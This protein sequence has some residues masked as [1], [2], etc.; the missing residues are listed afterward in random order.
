MKTDVIEKIKYIETHYPV[1]I[2]EYNGIKL[3]PFLRNNI[4]TLYYY[5]G[6]AP[7]ANEAQKKNKLWRLFTALK[8]E[9]GSSEFSE[10][11]FFPAPLF[12]ASAS[13]KI[14]IAVS[15]ASEVFLLRLTLLLLTASISIFA[16]SKI[17][18]LSLLN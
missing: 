2:I 15:S 9:S 4:F 16:C 6:E 8:E 18:G 7:E 13:F 10:R 3:W 11:T 17:S 5:S 12:S 14:F 1:E